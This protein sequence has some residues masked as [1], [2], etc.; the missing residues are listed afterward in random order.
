MTTPKLPP[1][2]KP[3]QTGSVE[4]NES[5]NELEHLI[6]D[7]SPILS[8]LH[9][10]TMIPVLDDVI[11]PDNMGHTGDPEYDYAGI[12]TAGTDSIS[13]DQ[14][15]NLINNVEEKIAGELDALVNILKDTI[16]DSIITELK[17]QLETEVHQIKSSKSDRDN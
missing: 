7:T 4:L 16:K 2:P 13:P 11:D 5:I 12:A 14:F 10:D 15:A 6:T 3:H 9:T 17:T 1:Q 8:D